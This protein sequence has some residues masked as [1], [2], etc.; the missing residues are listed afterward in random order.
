MQDDW[1]ES[2]KVLAQRFNCF[3]N[4]PVHLFRMLT[5]KETDFARHAGYV[6]QFRTC[7]IK[8]KV[9]VGDLQMGYLI[10]SRFVD[11]L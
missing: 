7:V 11:G 8:S 5:L 2:M 10:N 3:S 1:D 9:N 4:E 6:R